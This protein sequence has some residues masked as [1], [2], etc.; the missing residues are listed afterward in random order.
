MPDRFIPIAE[1]AGLVDELGEWVTI[2][3]SVTVR[4]IMFSKHDEL[5]AEQSAHAQ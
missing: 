2:D 4:V 5:V 1:A 3:S